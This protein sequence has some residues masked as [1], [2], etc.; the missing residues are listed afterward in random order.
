VKFFE[1]SFDN[2]WE[3]YPMKVTP[4]C[5]FNGP[6]ET[7]I[8]CRNLRLARIV[9]E[10]PNLTTRLSDEKMKG[11]DVGC[12]NR[13]LDIGELS[14]NNV[15]LVKG[16]LVAPNISSFPCREARP[17]IVFGKPVVN[18]RKADYQHMDLAKSLTLTE[19]EIRSDHEVDV[20]GYDR[21]GPRHLKEGVWGF[22]L[23]PMRFSVDTT[24]E[25]TLINFPKERSSPCH[26]K[27]CPE[28][29]N[30]FVDPETE[31]VDFL[32]IRNIEEKSA[33]K[34]WKNSIYAFLFRAAPERD[35]EVW[36]VCVKSGAAGIMPMDTLGIFLE[37]LARHVAPEFKVF[38]FISLGGSYYRNRIRISW[39]QA[40]FPSCVLW[41]ERMMLLHGPAPDDWWGDKPYIKPPNFYS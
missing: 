24:I 17:M 14:R 29:E 20:L 10:N 30:G 33:R 23:M 27:V 22:V 28:T 41:P 25:H 31:E 35:K 11:L 15:N 12:L 37:T 2:F 26:V 6:K 21:Y 7:D 32:R 36:A 34:F 1:K 9:A 4:M 18:E 16:L 19:P 13:N 5:R 3:T 40:K 38:Q 8:S 39:T